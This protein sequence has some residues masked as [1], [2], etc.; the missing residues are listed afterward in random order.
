MEFLY[1]PFRFFVFL[2][3]IF[4][5]STATLKAQTIHGEVLYS[6]TNNWTKIASSMPFLSRE[7]RDRIQYSWGR[8]NSNADKMK[9]IFNDSVSYYTYVLQDKSEESIWS[10]RKAVYEIRRNFK[11]QTLSD[12]IDLLGKTYLIKDNIPKRKWIIRN[13]I[14]EIQGYVCMKAESYDSVKLQ[15]IVAWFTDQILVPLGPADYGGLPGLILE[16]DLN[17]QSSIIVAESIDIKKEILIPSIKAK[18]KLINHQKYRMLVSNYI[19]DC[20]DRRR[21]PYWDLQ[22]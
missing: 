15:K 11:E 13:E 9:L 6:K 1:R 7:E 20:I 19:K 17:D 2:I 4:S 18:G 3:G 5:L 16:I 12:R 22:Y 21:N 8:S 14:K 10:Y